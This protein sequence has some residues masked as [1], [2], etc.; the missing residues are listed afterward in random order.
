M[1]ERGL[2]RGMEITAETV[3]ERVR[4]AGG[5][6]PL[7]DLDDE[8]LA[9]WRRASK[10]VQLRLLRVGHERLHRNSGP[11]RLDLRLTRTD[12]EESAAARG[13]EQWSPPPPVVPRTAEFVGRTVPVRSQV[14]KPHPLLEQLESALDWPQQSRQDRWGGYP[15]PSPQRPLQRMRRIWQA[16]ISE[17]LFRGYSVEFAHNRRDAYDRGQLIIEI[18]QDQFPLDLYGDRTT[19]LRLRITEPQP[20]RRRDYDIWTD[21][22]ERPLQAALGEVFTHI[23][24]RAELLIARREQ[25]RQQQR[26]WQRRRDRAEAEA[27]KQFA[28]DHR[29]AALSRRLDAVRVADDAGAYAAAL[30]A[31]AESLEPARADSVRAW[32]DWAAAYAIRTDPRLTPAGAPTPPRPT[33]GDLRPYLRARGF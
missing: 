13:Y 16:I 27:R 18:G 2:G 1:V 25:E 33:W 8:E 19:P 29:R 26:E 28:E 17:A 22:P 12:R 24:Q 30:S 32:A 6:L 10:I 21:S 15:S 4:A 11:G 3:L 20:Q 5:H 31:A 14:S 7:E 23:E 9:A